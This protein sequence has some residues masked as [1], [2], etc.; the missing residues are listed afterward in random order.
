[1]AT[2]GY[3]RNDMQA[4]PLISGRTHRIG[5]RPDCDLSLKSRSV[6][7][8]HAEIDVNDKQAVLRDLASLNGC[9]INNVRLKGQRE[10]L[11]HG[12]NVRFG[13]DSRIWIVEAMSAK[14]Q[15]SPRKRAGEGWNYSAEGAG[16]SEQL[17]TGALD[18]TTHQK[19][20]EEDRDQ[21]EQDHRAALRASE[22]PVFW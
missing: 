21:N 16:V 18:K 10:V 14:E 12:D 4:L 7:G 6:S 13:F 19:S 2:W 1:M 9:F 8:D 22:Q 20:R 17:E 15:A 5:R 3:L 11:M